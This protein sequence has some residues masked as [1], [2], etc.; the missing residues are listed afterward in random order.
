MHLFE[1]ALQAYEMTGKQMWLERAAAMRSKGLEYFF[2]P[3]S[4]TITEFIAPDL[5]TLPGRDGQRREIGHQCEWAW[6]LMREVDL[7]GDASMR[8]IAARL[9]DFADRHGFSQGGIMAGAA[10]DAVS[11]DTNW[12]EDSFLLWPQTEAIKTYAVRADEASHAES[13]RA[14]A[15]LIFRK[16]FDG[17]LAFANQLDVDGETLWPDAL[18]RLHYHLVLALTEGARAGLWR[19]PA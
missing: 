10:F 12:R 6:L 4:G 11:A 3:D 7:G 15:L 14:L 2:D 16:Y 9:L 18:S 1:A 5:S 13:A 19:Y 17:R 8:D